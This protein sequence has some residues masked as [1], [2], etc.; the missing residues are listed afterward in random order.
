MLPTP[1]EP[2][3]PPKSQLG[4]VDDDERLLVLCGGPRQPHVRAVQV[5]KEE[6]Q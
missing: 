4:N 1:P 5:L 2:V 6:W 3:V